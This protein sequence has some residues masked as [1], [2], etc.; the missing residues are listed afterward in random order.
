MQ[1]VEVRKGAV[2]C[3]S[4]MV[5]KKFGQ[6]HDKVVK[7]I[8][9]LNK[10]LMAIPNRP[11]RPEKE[12]RNYRGRDYTAYLIGREFFSLLVMRFKGEKA[13]EWQVKFNKAFYDMERTI[14]QEIL[15]KQN[16]RW[17]SDRDKSKQVRL[18]TT[19]VIKDFVE[20]ATD[21]GSKSATF[22]YKHITNATYKALGLLAQR[23]PKLRDTLDLMELSH[24]TTAEYVAQRSI[25]KHME[26]M[27]PYK[28]VYDF[29]KTDLEAFAEGLLIGKE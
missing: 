15:N 22:Y 4:S 14:L 16:D 12:M 28:K 27:I 11:T 3:D 29:V 25:K 24:L 6:K 18:E 21:Q 20:Y 9:N 8:A 13:L 7:V 2:L 17:I 5:A 19:D 23:K 1:L 10:A 26:D